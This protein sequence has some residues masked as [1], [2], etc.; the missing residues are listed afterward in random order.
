MAM[1]MTFPFLFPFESVVRA[2]PSVLLLLG[3][4]TTGVVYL[5]S[6][7]VYRLYISPIARFPG[8]KLAALSRWYEFYYDCILPGQFSFHI[9]Q[10]HKQYGKRGESL[11]EQWA[12]I[13]LFLL[14]T[15]RC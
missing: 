15:Y 2:R 13:L 9:Q 11:V 1:T 6:L 5:A 8:P 10:L 12:S 3:V 4:V 7:A 14:G